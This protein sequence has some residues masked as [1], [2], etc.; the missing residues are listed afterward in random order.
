M[1]MIFPSHIV[2]LQKA[3]NARIY[4]GFI[5]NHWIGSY[6]E[7]IMEHLDLTMIWPTKMVICRS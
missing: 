1:M 5:K 6:T 4:R 7:K 2:K 3:K